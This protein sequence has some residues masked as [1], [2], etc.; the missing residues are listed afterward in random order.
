VAGRVV[1]DVLEVGRDLYY[2]RLCT[3]QIDH[4]EPASSGLVLL[5]VEHD[6]FAGGLVGGEIAS[7]EGAA[8]G[9]VHG[10]GH[11][12]LVFAPAD[13]GVVA[14]VGRGHPVGKPQEDHE[15]RSVNLGG[16]GRPADDGG[17][18]TFTPPEAV[19]EMAVG[20]GKLLGA[21]VE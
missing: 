4:K 20:A 3:G 18:V 14:V 12:D 17:V 8:G 11:L 1:Q 5:P 10:S 15:D 19:A 9:E 7:L 16:L 6:L 13:R 21:R 2:A